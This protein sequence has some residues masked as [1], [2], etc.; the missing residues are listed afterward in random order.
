MRFGH[1]TTSTVF[2]EPQIKQRNIRDIQSFA[3]PFEFVQGDI[4]DRVRR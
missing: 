2:T 3:K 1:S 4:T